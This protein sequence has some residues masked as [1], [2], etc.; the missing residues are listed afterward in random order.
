MRAE[1][2]ITEA[3][4]LERPSLELTRA[5]IEAARWCLASSRNRSVGRRCDAR[6]RHHRRLCVVA[7]SRL[8]YLRHPVTIRGWNEDEVGRRPRAVSRRA[9]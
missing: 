2:L 7:G 8:P 1:D 3:I 6:A 5:Y 9:V 4:A